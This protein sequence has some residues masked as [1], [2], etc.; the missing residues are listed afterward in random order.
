MPS[1]LSQL[2]FSSSLVYSL[3]SSISVV[4][5]IAIITAL[6]AS[7]YLASSALHPLFQWITCKS[8]IGIIC[9]LYTATFKWSPMI[10]IPCVTKNYFN[11]PAIYHEF[12]IAVLSKRNLLFFLWQHSAKRAADMV[13]HAWLPT[14]VSVLLDSQEATARKVRKLFL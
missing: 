4:I 9:F 5:L 12:L 2:Y 11:T 1:Y 6:H 14:N 10:C 3:I 8:E 7:S 13:E